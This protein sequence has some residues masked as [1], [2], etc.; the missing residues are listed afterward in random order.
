MMGE[1]QTDNGLRAIDRLRAASRSLSQER[2]REATTRL[3][4]ALR[5]RFPVESVWIFGS[6]ARMEATPESDLDVLVSISDSGE[7]PDAK[8]RHAM[9]VDAIQEANLSVGGRCDVLLLTVSEMAKY[10][11]SGKPFWMEIARDAQRI[12]PHVDH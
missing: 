1:P 2:M 3:I 10:M 5:R 9:A 11:E 6:S 4:P 7:P 12:Y 8:T